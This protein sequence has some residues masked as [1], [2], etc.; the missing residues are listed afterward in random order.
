MDKKSLYNSWSPTISETWR[1]TYCFKEIT[2]QL[3]LTM[4]S[5]LKDSIYND[6]KLSCKSTTLKSLIQRN[7]S[8]EN[9]KLTEEGKIV[10]IS[11]LP[12]KKQAEVLDIK[13]NNIKY[14]YKDY[15]MIKVINYM[16]NFYDYT[17]PVH[18]KAMVNYD[19]LKTK[20]YPEIVVGNKL[21]EKK[22]YKLACNDEGK[23]IF[24]LLTCM[25]YK[26]MCK[27]WS[28]SKQNL[29]GVTH[30]IHSITLLSLI[31]NREDYYENLSNNLIQA[32]S[33]TNVEE[34]KS[35]FEK[36]KDGHFD[37]D[38]DYTNENNCIGIN[39]EFIVELYKSL[40]NERMVNVLK[41]YLL[42]PNSLGKG[43]PDITA[44]KS[45]GKVKLIEV[46]TSD[47]LHI[48]QINT[49]IELKKIIDIEIF[50]INKASV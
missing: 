11:I 4:K 2:K 47:K 35:A 13:I 42:D 8:D 23:S 18:Y 10:G 22:E 19:L 27:A 6:N 45:D 9:G 38:C 36:I 37:I 28:D 32:A 46:K 44:I 49:F 14:G 29:I 7:L 26:E 25:C 21:L 43:W 1:S 16:D 34:I 31:S 41:L 5:A 15:P 12:L 24:M 40:G 17:N 48:S 3:S 20:I 50:K 30:N 33:S 39:N